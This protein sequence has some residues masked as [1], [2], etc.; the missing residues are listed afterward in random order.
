MPAINSAFLTGPLSGHL[1]VLVQ[2]YVESLGSK[3]HFVYDP[4]ANKINQ[5]VSE[6]IFGLSNPNFQN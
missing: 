1:K 5:A 3:N 4:L 2:N 6:K